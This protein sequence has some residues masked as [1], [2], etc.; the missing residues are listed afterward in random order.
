MSIY[1]SNNLIEIKKPITN[2]LVL[3]TSMALPHIISSVEHVDLATLNN[4]RCLI[5]PLAYVNGQTPSL[6]S[7][8]AVNYQ[9]Y[10]LASGSFENV[11]PM[12]WVKITNAAGGSQLAAIPSG[13]IFV[14][15]SLCLELFHTTV[16]DKPYYGMIAINVL[17]RAGSILLQVIRSIGC[18]KPTMGG[19]P[20]PTYNGNSCCTGHTVEAVNTDDSKHYITEPGYASSMYYGRWAT[21]SNTGFTISTKLN[22][23]KAQ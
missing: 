14:P 3:N 18:I 23:V 1:I 4:M 12:V 5:A 17:H 21:I 15:G 2:E 20:R 22:L 7:I 9:E 8:N 13:Y 6:F 11:V 10:T 19:A 16:Y